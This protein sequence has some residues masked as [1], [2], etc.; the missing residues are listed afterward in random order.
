M[1]KRNRFVSGR[2]ETRTEKSKASWIGEIE[3]G[4]L[5]DRLDREEF[6]ATCW[7][8]DLT[9]VSIVE[10][11]TPLDTQMSL[12]GVIKD[13]MQLRKE[14]VDGV[15]L[16]VL[17]LEFPLK[18]AIIIGTIV[19]VRERCSPNSEIRDSIDYSSKFMLLF[20]SQFETEPSLH[21]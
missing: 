1:G 8:R 14:F 15:E 19:S 4:A 20:I 18:L 17:G 12:R 5:V 7:A 16:L 3:I 6:T 21:C 11:P 13:E 2:N 9:R 10:V